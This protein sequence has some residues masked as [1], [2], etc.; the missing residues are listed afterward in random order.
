MRLKRTEPSTAPADVHVPSAGCWN[1]DEF[2]S[3]SPFLEALYFTVIMTLQE[4]KWIVFIW[5]LLS[6]LAK[7]WPRQYY[8]LW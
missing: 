4:R 8:S 6:A 7:Y 5:V 3:F 2:S 1:Q